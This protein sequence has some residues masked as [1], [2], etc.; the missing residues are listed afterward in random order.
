MRGLPG[1]SCPRSKE[2]IKRD[3]RH[4]LYMSWDAG[5]ERQTDRETGGSEGVREG[6]NGGGIVVGSGEE[7][8][9][10]I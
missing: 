6:E 7:G 2:Y 9:N 5:T 10:R 1:A 3:L 4:Q 8:D